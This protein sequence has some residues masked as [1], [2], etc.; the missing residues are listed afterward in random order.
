MVV[1]EE[2]KGDQEEGIP[3][4]DTGLV[5]ESDITPVCAHSSSALMS[6]WEGFKLQGRSGTGQPQENGSGRWASIM[7]HAGSEV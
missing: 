4:T 1:K 3:L 5:Q 7:E 2:M 6:V